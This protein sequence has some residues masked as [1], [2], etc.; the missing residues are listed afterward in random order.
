M[1]ETLEI[2]I[3]REEGSR[4]D[5]FQAEY[6]IRISKEM[7]FSEW[8]KV[9]PPRHAGSY[10]TREAAAVAAVHEELRLQEPFH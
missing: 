5:R 2:R 10:L 3:V 1:P 9:P 6:R 4:R 7:A 8:H